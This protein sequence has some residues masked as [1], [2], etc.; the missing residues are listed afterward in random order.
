MG[1]VFLQ[2][3]RVT[4]E[5]VTRD[6]GIGST[7]E[8]RSFAPTFI[9]TSQR[10]IMSDQC[11]IAEYESID[12]MKS[13]L[14]AL[15]DSGFTLEEYSVVINA[16]DQSLTILEGEHPEPA[17]EMLSS[18]EAVNIGTFLGGIIAA[19]LAAGTLIGPF[20][21]VGSL[22]GM[23]A[24]ATIGGLFSAVEHL[25]VT[26]DIGADYERRVESGSTLIIVNHVDEGRIEQARQLLKNTAPKT[27]E[28][29]RLA[30]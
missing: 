11:L 30:H 25:G 8:S 26:K 15:K 2:T 1:G 13:G 9:L 16:D 23:V 18:S 3:R 5:A 4:A 28:R 19:P 21:V 7:K 14:M 17:D 24:G 20:I 27:L 6:C 29:F 12:R 22:V 10:N